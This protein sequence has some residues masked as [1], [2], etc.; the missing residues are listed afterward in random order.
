M[1]EVQEIDPNTFDVVVKDAQT[2]THRVTVSDDYYEKLTGGRTPREQ[3]IRDS[4]EFLLKRESNTMIF[5]EFDFPVI[6][7]YFPQYEAEMKKKTG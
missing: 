5:S 6:K 4:F 1:V 2:T 7:G 3:L